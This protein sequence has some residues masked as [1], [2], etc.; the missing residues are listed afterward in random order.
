MFVNEI[1]GIAAP[2]TPAARAA[3]EVCAAHAP[4]W[5][6]AH[7]QRAFFLGAAHASSAAIEY[8]PEL[9]FV[10]ALLHDI[11][12]TPAFDAHEMPFEDAGARV[13]WVFGAGAGW[14]ASRR[15]RVAEVIV[16]H[17][18]DDVPPS[19]DPESHLLQVSTTADVSGRG[20]ELFSSSFTDALLDRFPRK[21]FAQGFL[22]CAT[23]EA[24]RK[25]KSS[26]GE[27]MRTGWAQR[28]TTNALDG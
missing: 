26:S 27:L 15:D 3:V 1:N 12:L 16:L 17:M 13:A 4:D 25:P 11:A 14:S 6:V 2:D 21:G 23:A 22:E 8:D 20:L 9:L 10:A 18:R 24:T 7:S 5:L 19:Q 28:I